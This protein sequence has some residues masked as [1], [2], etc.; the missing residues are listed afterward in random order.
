MRRFFCS[1]P[2]CGQY[3]I[4]PEA[5]WGILPAEARMGLIQAFNNG[6]VQESDAIEMEFK[7]A[8]PYC[9]GG[10]DKIRIVRLHRIE[11]LP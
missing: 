8:C 11:R 6:V 4:K 9:D 3:E 5:F 1:C 7:T 10:G 2:Q